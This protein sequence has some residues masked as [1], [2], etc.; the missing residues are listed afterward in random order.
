MLLAAKARPVHQADDISP[1]T[2]CCPR[3][4]VDTFD[5]TL[6]SDDDLTRDVDMDSYDD[7]PEIPPLPI[8]N[9]QVVDPNVCP[10]TP[11]DF[12]KLFPSRDRLSIRHDDLTPDG[13]LNLRVDTVLPGRRRQ[14][15]QLFHLR[16][17]DLAKREFS[18]RRYCRDSG[19][20]V[21][22]SKRKYVEEPAPGLDPALA[23]AE[24]Q[25]PGIARSVSSAFRSLGTRRPLTRT[26]SGA[27]HL[28]AT[29]KK[30]GKRPISG[31]SYEGDDELASQFGR[32]MSFDRTSAPRQ[33]PLPT[34]SMKLEFSNYARVDVTRC[35]SGASKR[36]EFE[37]W[38]H[39]YHW[40]RIADK[41]LGSVSFH[42]V[43][44]GSSTPVAHIVPETRSPTQVMADD[45]AGGWVPPC[46]MWISDQSIVDAATDVA[47][48][49]IATGLMA[50]VDDCIKQRWGNKGAKRV[51]RFALPLTSRTLDFEYVGPRS[52]MNSLFHRRASDTHAHNPRHRHSIRTY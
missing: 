7:C 40:K 42:L 35:G 15:M 5:S 39:R 34:N 2:S 8:Y 19:R 6:A 17:Y 50:L 51:H 16:M 47:D 27:S 3:S 32:S 10:S 23:P 21:C 13:N 1:S 22:N 28:S 33:K 31:A 20:E 14:T 9:H 30:S 52:I 37:W 25:R 36:Y 4:S 48:V 45:E 38:G 26:N 29:S 43:R 18:L 41:T 49:V 46:H 12:G 44:D 24:E 11:N